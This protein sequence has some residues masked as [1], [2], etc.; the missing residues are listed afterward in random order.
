MELQCNS[1]NCVVTM[2]HRHLLRCN[3]L[4]LH[5]LGSVIL[6]YVG[7]GLVAVL[8]ICRLLGIIGRCALTDVVILVWYCFSSVKRAYSHD[9]LGIKVTRSSEWCHTLATVRH[10]IAVGEVCISLAIHG[11]KETKLWPKIWCWKASMVQVASWNSSQL[12][13]DVFCTEHCYYG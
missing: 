5:L 7:T 9:I 1:A 2:S 4:L 12:W 8:F 13:L 6:K 3:L 10:I 11:L